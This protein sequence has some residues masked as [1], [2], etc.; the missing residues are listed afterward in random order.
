MQ[1][2]KR[3][4]CCKPSSSMTVKAV[5]IWNQ[6]PKSP[7]GRLAESSDKMEA[8][9]PS[10][11]LLTIYR[12]TSVTSHEIIFIDGLLLT[13]I[14]LRGGSR[15]YKCSDQIQASWVYV[16][17]S[18]KKLYELLIIQAQWRHVALWPLGSRSRFSSPSLLA[19]TCR[20]IFLIQGVPGCA[21]APPDMYIET[22]GPTFR[23]R[24]LL[25]RR[26]RHQLTQICFI[27]QTTRR[28]V[29]E[30]SSNLSD[31]KG[32]WRWCTTLVTAGFM[33]FVYRTEF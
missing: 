12:T 25:P 8:A 29:P 18:I 6:L 13:A 10:E 2:L 16:C 7:A 28:Y 33:D 15:L 20:A 5:G 3:L 32:F 23:G 27:Y 30:D 11:T 14:L 26:W 21:V 1:C 9:D 4:Q 22:K 24:L 31:P 17:V 19:N